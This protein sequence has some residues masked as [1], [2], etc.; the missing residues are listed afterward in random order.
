MS[1]QFLKMF[2]IIQNWQLMKSLDLFYVNKKLYLGIMKPWKTLDEVIE[3]A[4]NTKYGLAAYVFSN[5]F[6]S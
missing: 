6:N 3:R 5:D 1:Q 4:N 2:Q